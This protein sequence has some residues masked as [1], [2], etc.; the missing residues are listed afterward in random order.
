MNVNTE[1]TTRCKPLATLD[2]SKF[3]VELDKK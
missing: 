1:V 2:Y 3:K